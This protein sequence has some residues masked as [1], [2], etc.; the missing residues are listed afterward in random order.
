[1]ALER[2]KTD[3]LDKLFDS[4]GVLD[5]PDGASVDFNDRWTNSDTP[6]ESEDPYARFLAPKSENEEEK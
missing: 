6:S 3:D 4:L 5:L 1:M 2:K